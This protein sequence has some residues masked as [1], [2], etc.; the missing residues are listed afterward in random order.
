MLSRLIGLIAL[1]AALLAVATWVNQPHASASTP[2][3]G[4][5]DALT[6]DYVVCAGS[7]SQT[8][9]SGS[10]TAGHSETDLNAR[11]DPCPPMA[12]VPQP[13]TDSKIWLLYLP[14]GAN[15]TDY[16]MRT[17]ECRVDGLGPLITVVPATSTP[18]PDPQ[19]VA[20]EAIARLPVP[21]PEIHFGPDAGQL[22]VNVPVW[23]WVANP[24]PVSASATDRTVTVTATAQ[25]GW[26]TWSMG[27]PGAADVTC[28]G[29]GVAPELGADLW[30]PPCGYT[31]RLRSLAERTAG[32]GTWPVTAEVTWQITWSANTGE[33]GADRVT[34]SSMAPAR[35]GEWR[36]VIVAGS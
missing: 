10:S 11:V 21:L 14:V 33:S 16:V 27:E 23:L 20:R 29:P 31:Y 17:Q 12:M 7:E 15:P 8:E 35:I 36:T 24:D 26:V 22:A 13:P 18:P 2:A 32:A 5:Y 19:L 4:E 9:G 6:G 1:A 34:T 30:R 28:T 3:C 25:L